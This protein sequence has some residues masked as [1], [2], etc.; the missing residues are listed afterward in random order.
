MS[1]QASGDL[2]APV[3]EVKSDSLLLPMPSGPIAHPHPPNDVLPAR[4]AASAEAEMPNMFYTEVSEVATNDI[5]ASS[6][7][8]GSLGGD[9]S[10]LESAA[11]SGLEGAVGK[12][13]SDEQPPAQHPRPLAIRGLLRDRPS[14]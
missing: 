1:G 6:S 14:R 8:P 4:F 12:V 2:T 7:S 13:R 3:S 10:G 5:C 9:S 11:S